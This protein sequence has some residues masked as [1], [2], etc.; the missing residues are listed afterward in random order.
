M[1]SVQWP[2]KLVNRQQ[3]GLSVSTDRT[4]PDTGQFSGV[5]LTSHLHPISGAHGAYLHAKRITYV[6]LSSEK[7]FEY[8]R[9]I[10]YQCLP[11]KTFEYSIRDLGII[12]ISKLGTPESVNTSN[13]IM[14]KFYVGRAM[15]QAV[16]R[17]L[18]TADAPVRARVN[19]CGLCGG[20]TGSRTVISPSSSFFPCQYHSNVAL[21]AHISS[22]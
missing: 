18:L 14:I 13:H 22:G 6:F 4:F 1:F 11:N 20:Q 5:R 21:H 8:L 7:H 15:A 10:P 3:V 12:S 16:S 2:S 9:D 17:W 19:P